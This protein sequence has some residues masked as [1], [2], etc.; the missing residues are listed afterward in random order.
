MTLVYRHNESGFG[1]LAIMLSDIYKTCEYVHKEVHDNELGNCIVLNGFTVVDWENLPQPQA[2][3]QFCEYTI[4]VV[5]PRIR[6]IVQPTDYM[7]SLIEKH[8][9]LVENVS[10]GIHIRR[11]AYSKDSLQTSLEP[12]QTYYQCSDDSLSKFKQIIANLQGRV[13]V[14]SDSIETKNA[15]IH[16]FGSKVSFLDTEFAH[17]AGHKHTRVVK[18]EN[19]HNA[20]LEWFLLSMCPVLYLTGGRADLVGFSTF[21]YTAAVYGSKP[22]HL[23]F[24]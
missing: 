10:A 13:Y 4:Q 17:T 11:G 7:K 1:N 24:N 6:E 18:N 5:H 9:H 22:F 19:L 12:D 16:E 15:I 8:K 3:I 2:K 21:G 20:Y 23:I 14:A